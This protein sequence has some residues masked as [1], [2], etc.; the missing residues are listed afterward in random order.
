MRTD[1]ITR[2]EQF[3]H[4]NAYVVEF[5]DSTIAFYSYNTPIVVRH[6]MQWI[7]SPAKYSVSTTR[8]KNRFIYER[9]IQPVVVEHDYFVKVLDM[10]GLEKGLA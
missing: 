10:L 7:T 9:Q 5:D 2:T 4:M 3:H 6:N 8:Q 1:M